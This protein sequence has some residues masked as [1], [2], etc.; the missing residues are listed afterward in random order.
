MDY[1]DAFAELTELRG[2]RVALRPVSVE[3][4][5]PL[6][7]AV[8][9]SRVALRRYMPW[10]TDDP[11]AVRTFLEGAVREREAGTGLSLTIF[12]LETGDISGNM[13]LMD[14]DRFTPRA[15]LG[16][17]IRSSKT[18]RG[19]ATEAV[20]I[21]LDYC[22][23]TLKIVRVDAQV[24]TTNGASQRVLGKCGFEEEGLKPKSLLCHGTWHDMNMYGK[25]LD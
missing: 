25:L 1:V 9:E 24:V 6:F 20:S 7:E 23:E 4:G 2:Q 14:L 13:G 11:E 3:W 19:Y 5:D 18:G 12:D 21:L 8:Y 17:W 16:Y 10:E 22:R 15:E